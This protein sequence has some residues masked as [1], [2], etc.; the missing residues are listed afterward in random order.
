MVA[1]RIPPLVAALVAVILATF[2]ARAQEAEWPQRNIRLIVNTA[3]GGAADTTSRIVTQ[4]LTE[5]LGWTIVIEN[6]AGASGRLGVQMIARALP[7]GYTPG[8]PAAG[9]HAVP[10]GARSHPADRRV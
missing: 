8:L 3:A 10:T 1:T 6:Q 9:T 2:A 5:R 4:K 7:D